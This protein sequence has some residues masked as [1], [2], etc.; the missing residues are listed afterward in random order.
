MIFGDNIDKDLEKVY[1]NCTESEKMMMHIFLNDASAFSEDDIPHFEKA[2]ADYP[3]DIN[4]GPKKTLEQFLAMLRD[5]KSL[6]T[7][8]EGVT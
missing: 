8:Y 5:Y 2:I 7:K 4:Q 6:T 3:V 1:D